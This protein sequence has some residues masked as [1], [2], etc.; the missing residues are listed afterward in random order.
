MTNSEIAAVFEH[1]AD[2]LEFQG[3][4][5]VPRPAP[6]AAQP[7]RSTTLA[8]SAADIVADPERS[9][10]DIEGIGKDLAEKDRHAGSPPARCRCS[11]SCWPRF[12][13][14]F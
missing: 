2:L 9:L 8:E 12:P 10:L 14:A 7:G 3:A 11:T 13:K 5:S 1:V 6:I 4:K